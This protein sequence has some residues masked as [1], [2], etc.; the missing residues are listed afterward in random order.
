[1]ESL[2]TAH[3]CLFHHHAC[4]KRPLS[5]SPS[6][7]GH[8]LVKIQMDQ[9]GQLGPGL[10]TSRLELLNCQGTLLQTLSPQNTLNAHHWVSSWWLKRSL[11]QRDLLDAISIPWLFQATSGWTAVQ[12]LCSRGLNSLF[13]LQSSLQSSSSPM[14]SLVTSSWDAAGSGNTGQEVRTAFTTP[15]QGKAERG[16]QREGV[17]ELPKLPLE[18]YPGNKSVFQKQTLAFLSHCVTV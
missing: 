7:C 12:V 13:A 1:M 10:V 18:D 14:N 8:D 11:A 17:N 16:L 15:W 9:A 4:C 6:A 5:W 3:P 2:M